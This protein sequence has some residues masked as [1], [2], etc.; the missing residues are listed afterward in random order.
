[1]SR[2]LYVH[3]GPMKTGTSAIQ[4][5]LRNHDNSVIVYPKVGLWDDGSHHGLVFK[6]FGEPLGDRIE[7]GIDGLLEQI[8]KEAKDS[9]RD[10]LI[11]SETLADRDCERFIRAVLPHVTATRMEVEIV[12]ACRE[13]FSRASSLF[14]H[15]LRG[16]NPPDPDRFLTKHAAGMC[17]APL[18]RKMRETSF[19]VVALDYHPSETWVARFFSHLGFPPE[20]IPE[21]EIKRLALSPKGIIAKLAIN[22]LRQSKEEKLRYFHRFKQMPE[23]RAGSQFIFGRDAAAAAERH[24]SADRDFLSREFGIHFVAPQLGTQKNYLSINSDELSEIISIGRKLGPPGQEII[25]FARQY[26]RR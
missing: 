10:V 26:L 2:T 4:H 22:R 3:V 24:F 23:S 17:Y 13:H 19:R 21:G 12:V 9:E 20:R 18:I 7:G 1:M 15:R 8:G 5:A 11:S 6:F 25:R 14:N 16:G